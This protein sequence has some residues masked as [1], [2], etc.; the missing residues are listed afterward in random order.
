MSPSAQ[1]EPQAQR[2]TVST[3]RLEGPGPGHRLIQLDPRPPRAPCATAAPALPAPGLPTRT[4]RPRPARPGGPP[5]LATTRP[6]APARTRPARPSP[7]EGGREGGMVRARDS[8]RD[9]DGEGEGAAPT[10]PTRQPERPTRPLMIP[11]G[12][13]LPGCP[14]GPPRPPRQRPASPHSPAGAPTVTLYLA[15]CF[16]SIT[17]N[18]ASAGV[19]LTVCCALSAETKNSF[20][21]FVSSGLISM[22][23]DQDP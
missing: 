23:S 15:K 10:C 16:L 17:P 4:A 22:I 3:D 7:E 9:R 13:T 1:P 11:P 12:P 5:R 2:V 6:P 18:T 8:D 14:S 21:V 19:V 20:C